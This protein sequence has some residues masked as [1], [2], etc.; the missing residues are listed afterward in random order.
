LKL[1]QKIEEFFSELIVTTFVSGRGLFLVEAKQK[2]II[3]PK[4]ELNFR[5]P[6]P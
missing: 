6:S 2:P 5:P 1:N 3:S 4:K